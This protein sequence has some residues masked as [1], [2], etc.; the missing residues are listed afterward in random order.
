M[1]A[2]VKPMKVAAMTETVLWQVLQQ[3]V[4]AALHSGSAGRRGCIS[5]GTVLDAAPNSK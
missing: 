3:L 5:F 2:N 1:T 4:P